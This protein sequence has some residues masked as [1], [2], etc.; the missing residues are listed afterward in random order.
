MKKHFAQ[1]A[2]ANLVEFKAAA[3]SRR[4]RAS[5]LKRATETAA[6]LAAE[7][8]LSFPQTA[9]SRPSPHVALSRD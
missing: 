7:R 4:N 9:K 3:G 2:L 8:G 6:L 5:S 1:K